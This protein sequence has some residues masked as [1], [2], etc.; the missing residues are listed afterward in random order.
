MELSG[1]DQNSEEYLV[2]R[3]VKRDRAAFTALYECCVDRVY[4]HVYYS[5]SSRVDAEDITQ[6]VFIK[7][8]KAIDK[9]KKTGAPF[10]AWLLTI[11]GHLVIDHYRRRRMTINIDDVVEKIT[12]NRASDPEGQAEANYDKVLI[13]QA[14][15]KLKG[16]RQKVVLMHF[17]DGFS[18]G[19]IA[20]TLNKS[21]GAVRVIQYRA[22]DD[23]R[24]LLQRD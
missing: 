2:Q 15:L 7:A 9:Y 3:A 4:Q 1:S 5:V 10:I 13:R 23:L 20:R 8:W 21:E 18:Y 14:I 22:L 24:R 19:E 12:S 16:D 17:I 6:E 11:A